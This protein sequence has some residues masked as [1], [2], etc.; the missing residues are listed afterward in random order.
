[1]NKLLYALLAI[2]ISANAGWGYYIGGNYDDL[3]SYVAG[4]IESSAQMTI[5]CQ[6]KNTLDKNLVLVIKG[7]NRVQELGQP[8]APIT[9]TFKVDYHPP[10][11]LTG[12]VFDD[13]YVTAYID[14]DG[15]KPS[16]ELLESLSE[17]NRVVV[18]VTGGVDYHFAE[19]LTNAATPI[20]QAMD[21]CGFYS[22]EIS[23]TV[24]LNND[25]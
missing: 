7:P 11:T 12:R 3:D 15:S 16:L 17:E 5:E 24:G 21:V 10:I 4:E 9:A 22:N 19:D 14:L 13:S 2:P 6:I 20:S 1:M 8:G 18:K 25:H 23:E